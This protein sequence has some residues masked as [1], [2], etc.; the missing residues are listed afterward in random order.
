MCSEM[1]AET[2]PA[3]KIVLRRYR[4]RKLPRHECLIFIRKQ[5]RHREL[6]LHLPW[7]NSRIEGSPA[8][9]E[10]RTRAAAPAR[11]TAHACN[12]FL[13]LQMLRI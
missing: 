7:S 11:A 12:N 9:G 13:Q 3:R 8:S 10:T 1:G 4:P 5:Q 6:R 2:A